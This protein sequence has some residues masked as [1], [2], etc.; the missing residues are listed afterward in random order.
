MR[1]RD[2]VVLGGAALVWPP[3]ARA[4]QKPMQV[5]GSLFFGDPDTIPSAYFPA[6]RRGLSET[7]YVEGQNLTI[8]YRWGRDILIG[9]RHWAPISSLASLI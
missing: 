3:A 8:E 4:Q 9:C 1:R 6:L 7:G 2:F 5:I